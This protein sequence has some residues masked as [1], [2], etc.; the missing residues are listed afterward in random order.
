ML[1]GR[2]ST[3]VWNDAGKRVTFEWKAGA[4]FAIPL[5]CWHQH[6]NGSGSDP[7]ALRRGDQCAA[8]HQPLR[9]HRFRLQHAARFQQ[10]LLR[11]AGLFRRQGRAEGPAAGDQ[12]RRRCGQPAADR[13]QG[14]R[15]RRRPYPLQHGQGLDEQ[16]HLAV[17]DRHLQEGARA[18]AGRARD[19]PDR[20]GLFADVAGG[21]GAAP[22]RLAGRHDDR[23]AQHVVPPAF[24]HRHDAGALSRLQARGRGDP[25]RAG[26]AEGVDQ[27]ARRRRPDRLRRREAGGPH[28][29][30]RRNWRKRGLASK[31]DQAYAAELAELP[32]PQAKSA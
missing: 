16:P 7:G 23:A 18:R 13:R 6:F 17:P 10:P 29:V 28:H 9:R 19:H 26:R 8:G 25:Q 11:R 31:M 24:Q 1:S 12:L 2:G 4:M 22:L 27:P 14:A 20:R 21:R 3:T 15:R 32:N 5:N 30:R